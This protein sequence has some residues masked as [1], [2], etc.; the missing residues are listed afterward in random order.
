MGKSIIDTCKHWRDDNG[1]TG[2][3]GVV[4]IWMGKVHSWVN[5]L[6]DPKHWQPGCIAVNEEGACW[7]TI[8]GDQYYGAKS[9]ENISLPASSIEATATSEEPTIK[10][11]VE[12]D[13]KDAIGFHNFN[14]RAGLKDFQLEGTTDDAYTAMHASLAISGAIEE[15]I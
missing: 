13:L 8:G 11:E 6:R 5:E 7:K 4:V 10:I 14:R 15:K 2:K 1:Y 9:W 12:M 3:G